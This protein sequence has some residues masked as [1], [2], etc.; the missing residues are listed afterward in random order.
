MGGQDTRRKDIVKDFF[1][2]VLSTNKNTA[3]SQEY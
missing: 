1:I 3:D 2:G